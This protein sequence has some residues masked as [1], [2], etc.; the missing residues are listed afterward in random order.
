ME[1]ASILPFVN[2]LILVALKKILRPSYH[3]QIIM[4]AMGNNFTGWPLNVLLI[5]YC[6]LSWYPTYGSNL[7]GY[8]EL[9]ALDLPTYG[10]IGQVAESWFLKPP[11]I[12]SPVN[13]LETYSFKLWVIIF[14]S[15]RNC[16]R[17]LTCFLTNILLH[18]Y[19][20]YIDS[21]IL[22]Y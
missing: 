14:Y 10:Q 15:F 18:F 11:W 8:Y 13:W 2:C 12:V 6:W 22:N 17:T 21:W 5:C 4:R 1:N 16:F 19:L 7:V 3:I 9:P 20:I